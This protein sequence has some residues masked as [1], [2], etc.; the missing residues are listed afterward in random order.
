M[1]LKRVDVAKANE[2]VF[3]HLFSDLTFYNYVTI[4]GRCDD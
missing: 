3:D 4:L 1:E 2:A